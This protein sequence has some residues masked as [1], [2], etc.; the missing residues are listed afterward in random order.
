MP[1]MMITEK[2]ALPV[3]KRWLCTLIALV[4]ALS[5]LP[6]GALAAEVT[7]DADTF[8]DANFRVFL[9]NSIGSSF[10]TDS[11][12]FL[13]IEDQ[14]IGDLKGVELFT[15][16]VFLN[17]SHNTLTSL[18]MSRN[19]ALSFLNCYAN[20]I[21]GL[22]LRFNPDLEFLDCGNN[23]LSELDVSKQPELQVLQCVN[24]DLS[25]LDLRNN[26]KLQVLACSGNAKITSLDV[27]NNKDLRSLGCHG[28]GITE[29]DITKN[30]KLSA[31]YQEKYKKDVGGYY[32]YLCITDDGKEY[33]LAVDYDTKVIAAA[34]QPEVKKPVIT[35]Q[36][37]SS[38]VKAGK[39]ATFKVKA[40]GTGLKYQ[41]FVMK[42]GSKKWTKVNSATKATLKVKATKKM[43][44]YKYRCKVYNTAGVKY[45]K[46]VK[47]K[48]KK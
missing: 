33:I 41:W 20:K 26:T 43:N 34:P 29:L 2:E 17:C 28:C 40:T 16:L 23:K 30:P 1:D 22:D 45:T 12:Q 31:V 37:K 35:T 7:T 10:D 38:T 9:E 42:T 5:V 44:G 21:S 46:T 32:E 25:S 19:T 15:N 24:N 18:D 27:S 47:L 3:K 6:F 36:P 11:V 8:P 39:K 14:S 48:V 4:M 13:M